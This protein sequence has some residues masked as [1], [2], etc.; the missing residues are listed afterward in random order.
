MCLLPQGVF[1]ATQKFQ[2]LQS[3]ACMPDTVEKTIFC[4]KPG[5]IPQLW[6]NCVSIYYCILPFAQKDRLSYNL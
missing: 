6:Q 4:H 2:M 1:V 3:V 5:D